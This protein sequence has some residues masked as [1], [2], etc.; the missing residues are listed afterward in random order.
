MVVSLQREL[1][2]KMEKKIAVR[3]SFVETTRHMGLTAPRP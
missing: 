1:P 2:R 3:I